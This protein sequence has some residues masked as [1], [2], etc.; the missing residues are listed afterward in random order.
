VPRA[1]TRRRDIDLGREK[2]PVGSGVPVAV[3]DTAPRDRAAGGINHDGPVRERGGLAD[4]ARDIQN[5][6]GIFVSRE[7]E[8]IE[9]AVGGRHD[10]AARVP[11]CQSGAVGKGGGLHVRQR[12]GVVP[13]GDT[14]A[15]TRRNQK[16]AVGRRAACSLGVQ[17]GEA[18]HIVAENKP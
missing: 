9:R 5:D 1:E 3:E 14:G 7:L 8:P 13:L 10:S 12:R 11:A 16:V 6:P 2:E 15:K 17:L 4:L 18:H